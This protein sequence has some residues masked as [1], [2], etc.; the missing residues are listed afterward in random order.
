MNDLQSDE[1]VVRG[2]YRANEEQRGVAA[3]YDFGVCEVVSTAKRLAE[4]KVQSG[5]WRAAKL[6]LTLVL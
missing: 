2:R 3:V 6:P 1:L 5:A 4:K